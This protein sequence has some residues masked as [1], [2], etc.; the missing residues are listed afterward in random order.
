VKQTVRLCVC[1]MLLTFAF[2]L[3]GLLNPLACPHHMS[4]SDEAEYREGA[5]LDKPVKEGRGSFVNVGLKKEIQIDRQLDAGLR[6]TVK[7]K[8]SVE[9]MCTLHSVLVSDQSPALS[10]G[11]LLM[12]C[13]QRLMYSV[14]QK[15][16]P[17]PDDLW[18]FFQNG[19]GFF[20]QTLSAHYAFLSTLDYKFYSIIC[21]FDEVMQY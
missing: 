17:P 6:V 21:N 18:Q 16:S 4:Q 3:K 13:S 10:V 8:P 5:V 15:K 20:N 11:L 12:T 1:C 9:G 2:V 19:W 7:L 14:S